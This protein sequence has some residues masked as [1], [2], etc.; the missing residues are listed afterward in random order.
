MLS[1]NP[2]AMHMIVTGYNYNKMNQKNKVPAEELISTVMHPERASRMAKS[3]GI[4]MGKYIDTFS[5]VPDDYNSDNYS[6][7]EEDK[8]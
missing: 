1:A 7:N 3:H 5:N 2:N 6:H 4:S 8:K